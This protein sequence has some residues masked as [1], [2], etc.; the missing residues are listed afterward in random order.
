MDEPTRG[1]DIGAKEQIY[2][3]IEK[4]ARK[5]MAVIVISS[6]LP[7]LQRLC[8][9]VY[10]MKEGHITKRF[11]REELKDAEKILQYALTN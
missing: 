4:L 2:Q 5:N 3:V 7:E 10:V 1:I 8:D 9:S 11:E 6:E